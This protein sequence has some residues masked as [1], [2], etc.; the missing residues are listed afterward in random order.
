MVKEFDNT[1]WK[2]SFVNSFSNALYHDAPMSLTN[3]DVAL[4]IS[5]IFVGNIILFYNFGSFEGL[6]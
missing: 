6:L 5:V 1:F 3:C 4:G 2:Y